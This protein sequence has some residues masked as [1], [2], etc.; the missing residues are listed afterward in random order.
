[1]PKRQVTNPDFGQVG[2]ALRDASLDKSQTIKNIHLDLMSR[3]IFEAKPAVRCKISTTLSVV[4]A[5]RT[6]LCVI[7]DVTYSKNEDSDHDFV[8]IVECH[9][10]IDDESSRKN[11]VNSLSPSSYEN[12]CT[13]KEKTESGLTDD[14]SSFGETLNLSPQDPSL[15]SSCSSLDVYLGVV[16]DIDINE[17][18]NYLEAVQQAVQR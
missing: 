11:E 8:P 9:A 6:S 18:N 14:C 17:L 10:E 15:S 12:M 1:L 3:N 16:N 7:P 2:H 5:T 4:D 13:N